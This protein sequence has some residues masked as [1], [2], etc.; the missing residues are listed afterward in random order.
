MAE[1][2]VMAMI[3][4]MIILKNLIIYIIIL[5]IIRISLIIQKKNNNKNTKTNKDYDNFYLYQNNINDL[6]DIN[7]LT[8][9]TLNIKNN[10]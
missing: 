8:N 4:I 7:K 2:I 10:I 5:K 1:M 6:I 3:M 9:F